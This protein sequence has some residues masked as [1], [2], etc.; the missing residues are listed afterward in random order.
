MNANPFSGTQTSLPLYIWNYVQA[1]PTP[2]WS[3]G[4]SAPR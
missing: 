1:S 4:P 2:T 3:P